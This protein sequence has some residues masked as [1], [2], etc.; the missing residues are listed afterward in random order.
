M[1]FTLTNFDTDD[2]GSMQ[3]EE[4]GERIDDLK[5][6]LQRVS[7]ASTLFDPDGISIRFMNTDLPE[8]MADNVRDEASIQRIMNGV[9][10]SGLTP[11]G[12]ELKR[13]VIDGIILREA[14]A[15]RLKKPVL[16]I[17]VTDGQ[18]AGDAPGP[19]AV[20]D[21]IRYASQELARATGTQSAISFQFAQVGND[22][23]AREFLGKL[24][25][26]PGVGSL[27]DC[28]SSTSSLSPPCIH[29]SK[30]ANTM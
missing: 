14:S 25:S 17:A 11:M 30:K 24:D 4:N 8:G 6:I 27:V 3:F 2:S 10:Y 18:P 26:D 9:K 29:P 28:T 19:T 20:F 16:V 13:K 15:G 5:L 22:A 21:T 7:Y 23:K 1:K 12:K